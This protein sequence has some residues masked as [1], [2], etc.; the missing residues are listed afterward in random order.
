ML[1]V[2]H[3][4]LNVYVCRHLPAECLVQKLVLGRGGKILVASY[5]VGYAHK[6]IVNNVCEI[7]G[8]HTV[9]LDK[10]LVLKLC[11]VNGYVAVKLVVECDLT[12]RGHLLPDNVRRACIKLCL[13]LLFGEVAA[14]SVV[15]VCLA[16]RLKLRLQAVEP[17][18][19]AEAV[20]RLALFDKLQRI[21]FEHTHSFR[22]DIRTY[23]T[24]DIRSLVP[25]KT[26]VLERFIDD[27]CCA[28]NISS[29]V[30]IFDTQNEISALLFCDKVRKQRSTQVSDVHISRR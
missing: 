14:M 17:F 16:L 29:L 2:L 28:L 22:L 4:M 24:A 25:V 11:A 20:I 9:G 5:N 19:V 13:H 26:Y 8:R 30:G 7:V 21:L 27:L 6:V 10:Y 23:G 18:L 12:L 3:N 1:F 15:A